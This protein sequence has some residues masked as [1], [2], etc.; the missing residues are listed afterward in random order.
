MEHHH[1]IKYKL[2]ASESQSKSRHNSF[3]ICV[4]INIMEVTTHKTHFVGVRGPADEGG[5]G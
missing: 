5:E 1:V 4:C 3:T 2:T